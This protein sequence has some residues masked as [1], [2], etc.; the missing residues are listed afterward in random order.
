MN[1][2]DL[3]ARGP[4]RERLGDDILIGLSAKTGV[5]L[6]LLR[7]ALLETTG[8]H[9][10]GEAVFLARARHI[11]ALQRASQHLAQA[12][13]RSGDAELLAEE[14]RVAH[15]ALGS[16]LGRVTADDVLGE[17]FSRFCIGK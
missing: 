16:I 7:A 17:I 11:E 4:T 9:A 3:V 1:K 8:W 12:E 14:L 5:G 13:A 15:E 6:D 2:V 10:T